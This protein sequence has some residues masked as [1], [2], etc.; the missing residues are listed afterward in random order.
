M[1]T[2]Y[3]DAVRFLGRRLLTRRE[4]TLKLE[5]KGYEKR[6]IDEAIA[7]VAATYK[8]DDGAVSAD[9][10]RTRGA[11]RGKARVVGELAARGIDESA[12]E[13]AWD[14]AVASGA[15]D[16]AAS[17]ARAVV[18]RLG[19]APGRADKARLA[20]VYNALLSEGFDESAAFAALAPYGLERDDP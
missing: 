18:K 13:S 1:P 12:A 3:E 5:A 11:S 10:V 14:D 16:P 19:P 4:L 6:A 20:R 9:R 8:I 15:V 7:R 17:L 2:A